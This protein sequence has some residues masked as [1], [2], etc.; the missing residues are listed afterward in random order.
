M[1]FREIEIKF[2]AS[3]IKL[4]D[5]VTLVESSFKVKK[6]L[7]VSSY[8][9]YFVDAGGNFIRYRHKEGRGELTIKRKLSEHNNNTRVEVNLPT[10]GN[11][12]PAVTKFVELLGYNHNFCI[13]KTCTVYWVD[14]MVVVYYVVY[15]K[16]WKEQRRFI[17][18][19]AD[20]EIEWQSE[21]QALN[22]VA[23]CEK[24]FAALGLAPKNRLKKSLYEMFKKD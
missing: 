16:E 19:E 22:E 24:I 15:D 9:D 11:S 21:D 5:F 18:I 20:E 3:D 6:Q 17:E 14:N 13:Y 10:E 1:K 8:D 7:L 23:E 4:S 2:D 12:L